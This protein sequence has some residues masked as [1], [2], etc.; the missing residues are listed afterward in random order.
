MAEPPIQI[1]PLNDQTIAFWRRQLTVLEAM[2]ER[3]EPVFLHNDIRPG[4]RPG[5][6]PTGIAGTHIYYDER[7][8][9]RAWQELRRAQEYG[10]R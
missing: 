2:I 8:Y 7:D 10:Q 1:Q 4:F 6:G 9:Q 3:G 5:S